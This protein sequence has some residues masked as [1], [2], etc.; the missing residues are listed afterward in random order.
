MRNRGS[1][2]HSELPREKGER[3]GGGSVL[4]LQADRKLSRT[5]EKVMR[6]YQQGTESKSRN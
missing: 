6:S 2:P 4:L 3:K 1:E 5:R